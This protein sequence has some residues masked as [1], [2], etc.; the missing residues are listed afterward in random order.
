[1]FTLFTLFSELSKASL[2]LNLYFSYT[3][4]SFSPIRSIFCCPD[5]ELLS[6]FVIGSASNPLIPEKLLSDDEA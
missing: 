2:T 3:L 1:M 4:P 6:L 5:S